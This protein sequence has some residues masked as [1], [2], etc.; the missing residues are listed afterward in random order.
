MD[1]QYFIEEFFPNYSGSEEVAKYNDLLKLIN[2]EYEEGDNAHKLLINVYGGD[3]N[4]SFPKI[5]TDFNKLYTHILETSVVNFLKLNSA[6]V[7][8]WYYRT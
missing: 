4:K 6:M 5:E 1:I 7:S 3:I 2:M 8:S